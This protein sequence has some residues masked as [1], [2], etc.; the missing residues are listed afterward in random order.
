VLESPTRVWRR[1]RRG[2]RR[3]HRTRAGRCG[4]VA[5]GDFTDHELREEGDSFGP[6][7]EPV[8]VA[9]GGRP[10][11]TRAGSDG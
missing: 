11:I 3:A 7:D 10:G 9:P 6:E 8:P 5:A 2:R 4:Q 1:L